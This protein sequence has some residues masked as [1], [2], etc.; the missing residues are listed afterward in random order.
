LKTVYQRLGKQIC[1]DLVGFHSCTGYDQTGKF[2][3]YFKL[4]CW[5]IFKAADLIIL[6]AFQ[7]LGYKLSAD[8]DAG[9]E[10]YVLDLYCS[11]RPPSVS[12]LAE[13]R[14]FV[15]FKYQHDSEKLAPTKKTLD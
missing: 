14:W 9:L 7:K 12:N 3:G 11:K 5:K 15:F 10:N 2:R 6:N 13:L 4:S 8:V 1:K